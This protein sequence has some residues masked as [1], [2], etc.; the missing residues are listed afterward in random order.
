MA[1]TFN[2]PEFYRSPV[3]SRV[4]AARRAAD[5]RKKDLAPS[6]L[7]F[8]PL[9]VKMGRHFG[10]CF[11]VENAIEIAYRA[12][13][14]DP[15][16]AAAGRMFL[17]S[18]MIHNPHV[19]EDLVARGIR[20]LRTTSGEQLIPFDDLRPGDVVIVPAFGAP[21][22]VLDVLAAQGVDVK[23]YDTTC[24]FVVRVWKKGDQIGGKGYSVVVHGKR[25]HEETRA[26]F[27]RAA[28]SAPVVVVRDM[29]ETEALA[30]V[31]EGREDAAFFWRHFEGK[32]SEGFEV[33][34]DLARLG[35]VNQTTMLA[36]E[37]AAIAE[38][39]RQAVLT[40]DGDDQNVADTSD[41]LC[42]ATKENQ[43]ATDALIASG[44]DL[45]IVVGGYNSSNTSH[46]VELCEDA[47]LPTFFVRDADEIVSPDLIR[48]FDWRAK[49]ERE[50]HGWFPEARPVD[51]I[52]TAG[53]SCPDALLDGVIQKLLGYV[54]APRPVEDALAPFEVVPAAPPAPK[55]P[56]PRRPPSRRSAP[57]G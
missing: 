52:L 3:V 34:R 40:R 25:E 53:A 11:G 18:E 50:T 33:P 23:A 15:E 2:V 57:A 55:K 39:I 42:Y 48:H 27:S 29:A 44:A 35:V 54:D 20:F 12:L 6:V 43:D 14:E 10:F 41:T 28:A 36:T 4:K 30:A 37:T 13:A 56:P 26:T 21:T 31:V 38:R 16:A 17:L 45:A 1:R 9:R 24:P 19:N 47:G 49:T 5:P 46:L 32:T 51:V 8:G 7:D 22:E